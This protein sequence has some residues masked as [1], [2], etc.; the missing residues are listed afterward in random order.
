MQWAVLRARQ[1]G[2]GRRPEGLDAGEGTLLLTGACGQVV[3]GGGGF[4][5][6]DYGPLGDIVFEIE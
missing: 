2:C 5:R 1:N 3:P 4:Y 6:A